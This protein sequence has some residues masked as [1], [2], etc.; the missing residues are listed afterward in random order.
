MSK[1]KREK[2]T[3][4]Q[5]SVHS[6]SRSKHLFF[7]QLTSGL[8]L[9]IIC[10]KNR[11]IFNPI[12]PLIKRFHPVVKSARKKRNK[13]AL[14]CLQCAMMGMP[15]S[16]STKSYELAIFFSNCSLSLSLSQ[17]WKFISI[18]DL[19]CHEMIISTFET[20]L[21]HSFFFCTQRVSKSIRLFPFLA[22]N[23][24]ALEDFFV[25]WPKAVQKES[26]IFFQCVK[27]VVWW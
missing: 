1:E 15:L 16:T 3:H 18:G 2:K 12:P 26:L 25:V 9:I 27:R 10:W 19:W 23:W 21:D 6:F 22:I 7:A 17:I 5:Q 14:N 20:F 11:K 24:R 4:W 8:L 13:I